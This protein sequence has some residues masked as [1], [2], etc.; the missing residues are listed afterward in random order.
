MANTSRIIKTKTEALPYFPYI[1][2]G[3]TKRVMTKH[4]TNLSLW[5]SI[6]EIRMIGW[7]VYQCS[8]DNKFEYST[9]L[10]ERFKWSVMSA[11]FE[12]KSAVKK[13]D[14]ITARWIIE[15]LIKKGLVLHTGTKYLMINPMLSYNSDVVNTKQYRM[16][17]EFYQKSS[18]DE[19][20]EYFSK[21]VAE[22][23]QSKKIN[24]TYK[25]IKK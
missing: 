11:N 21:L 12:Y 9:R 3:K 10:L 25:L 22:Y 4:F 13:P 5:L 23:L 16:F 6:E 8:A 20:V 18:P 2:V 24:Y 7:L 1:Q 15:S 19:V 14:I 17:M